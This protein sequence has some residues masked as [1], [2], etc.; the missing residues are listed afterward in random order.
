[1]LRIGG[2]TLFFT[3]LATI[4]G[5]ASVVG[6][7]GWYY[8]RGISQLWFTI[9]ITISYIVLYITLVPAF[10]NVENIYRDLGIQLERCSDPEGS[11][12]IG[13]VSHRCPA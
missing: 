5:A 9:G 11:S 8:I 2:I 10:I 13:N 3:L 6:Y 4:V 7:T 1:M 12:D